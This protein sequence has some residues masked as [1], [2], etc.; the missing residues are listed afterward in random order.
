MLPQA[1]K[2]QNL[3]NVIPIRLGNRITDMKRIS[4]S[5]EDCGFYYI[6]FGEQSFIYSL[7]DF[8]IPHELAAILNL[9][10][11]K[12]IACEYTEW[13]PCGECDDFIYDAE[14]TSKVCDLLNSYYRLTFPFHNVIFVSGNFSVKGCDWKQ[15]GPILYRL[16]LD[17]FSKK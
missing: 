3:R 1:T 9:Y 15:H 4:N 13:F 10:S 17:E 14:L 11:G 16:E 8:P 6:V 12:H 2:I 7:F 5:G